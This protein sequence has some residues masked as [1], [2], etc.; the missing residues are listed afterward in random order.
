MA[1]SPDIYKKAFENLGK[2]RFNLGCIDHNSKSRIV[3]EKP[4]GRD[5]PSSQKLQEKLSQYFNE[6]QTY[7][8]DHYLGKETVQNIL[9]FRF[10][11]ELFEPVWSNKYIDSIQ[12]TAAE[13]VGIEKRGPYYD[14]TGALRDVV[15]NHLM[16]LI[17]LTTMNE[18]QRFEKDSIRPQKLEIVKS[19][20]KMTPDE[21]IKNTVRGQYEGY[22]NEEKVD[23]KSQTETYAFAK[24][25]IQNNRWRG[26]PIYVRTG[27]K[28]MGKVTSIIISF[29]ERGHQMFETFWDR[30]LP[31]HITLQ[32]QPNEGIGVTLVAKKPGLTTEVEP[33][34]ME[35]C[36]KTSFD[37]PNPD[38]YERLLMDIIIG[39]QTLFLGQ[40]GESWKVIDPIEEVWAS[41]KPK[42]EKYK[43]RTWG[44]A[45]ADNIL[46]RQKHYWLAPILT[47]CKI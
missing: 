35:F 12:I 8:I 40:V 24:L 13:D 36:Y 4:F 37:T 43:P 33:V 42:L 2:N 47:I 20:K 6:D 25:E 21:V 5:Y 17:T 34:N 7:R 39:D 45:K 44:P 10:G 3:I 29:K 30:P 28:L 31:N 32:I 9:T 19:I 11:N 1:I 26:V 18:P 16:Q 41:N 38:A 15:Q 23:P 46:A 22:S 14:K 27:K